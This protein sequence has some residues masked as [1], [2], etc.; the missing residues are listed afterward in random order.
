[1]EELQ[2][3]RALAE[4]AKSECMHLTSGILD[5]LRLVCTNSIGDLSSK[6]ATFGLRPPIDPQ[7]R[8]PT[9]GQIFSRSS[10]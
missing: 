1:M 4:N 5:C 10:R 3:L 6:C 9:G 2:Q 7:T 8:A